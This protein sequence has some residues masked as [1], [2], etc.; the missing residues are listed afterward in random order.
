VTVLAP[1]GRTESETRGGIALARLHPKFRT[2]TDRIVTIKC[3]SEHAGIC[4][5]PD[6]T[7]KSFSPEEMPTPST[8]ARKSNCFVSFRLTTSSRVPALSRRRI[9]I[10]AGAS[11]FLTRRLT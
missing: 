3:G 10:D 4:R 9:V 8:S 7:T 5:C 6:N 2:I 1:Q 11:P